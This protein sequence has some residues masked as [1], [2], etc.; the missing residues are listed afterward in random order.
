MLLF[1]DG[2]FT[3]KDWIS[4]SNISQ[5]EK[6]KSPATTGMPQSVKRAYISHPIIYLSYVANLQERSIAYFEV[7]SRRGCG[8]R[9]TN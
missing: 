6:K 7:S 4:L 9:F 5:S 2:G 3:D 8:A 1:D